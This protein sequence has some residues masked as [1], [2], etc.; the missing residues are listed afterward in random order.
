MQHRTVCFPLAF[1]VLLGSAPAWAQDTL[2]FRAGYTLQTD[3][4]LYRLP[5]SANTQALLGRSS[6]A[7]RIGVSLVGVSFNKAYSLQR[8]ELD[9]NLVDY[10]YKNFTNL[11]FTARNYTAAWRWSLT[12]RFYGSLTAD[13]KETLNSFSDYQNTSQITQRNQRTNT[14]TGFDGTYEIDGTWRLLG[15]FTNTKQTN[16]VA[17]GTGDDYSA[18]TASLG[19]R[20]AA[21]SASALTYTAKT[22]S[23]KY[24][25]RTRSNAAALDDEFSQLSNELRLYWVLSGNTTAN[26]SAAYV[27]RSHPNFA[28]RDYSGLNT[29]AAVNW[30][31]TGKTALTASYSHELAS[32]QTSYANYTQTDRLSIGPTYQVSPKVFL[33]LKYGVARIDYLD[34][35]TLVPTAQRKDTTHDTSLSLN[36]Q[37]Y[38]KIALSASV[39]KSTRDATVTNLQPLDYSSTIGTLSAQIDF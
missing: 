13:R 6:A 19:V 3:S 29:S 15:G 8:L 12:P 17:L 24:L 31:V 39:Q 4:N 33:G 7:E 38:Q 14:N 28:Q 35:P 18:D 22:S 37:P 23:G 10:S 27:S 2:T 34:A 30:A 11:S 9:L 5:D 21:S 20:Y 25:N 36:W 26:L 16:Q 1:L 32:F